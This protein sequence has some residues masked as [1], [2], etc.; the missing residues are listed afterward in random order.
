MASRIPTSSS[1]RSYIGSTTAPTAPDTSTV[2]QGQKI[3]AVRQDA[4]LTRAADKTER[5]AAALGTSLDLDMYQQL[6]LGTTYGS[7]MRGSGS[8]NEALRHTQI[9][10]ADSQA[11]WLQQAEGADPDRAAQAAKAAEELGAA[12]AVIDEKRKHGDNVI[13]FRH[14]APKLG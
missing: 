11:A 3:V 13:I 1:E 6:I 9:V 5:D 10:V 12:E 4:T 2:A 7:A 8:F 14:F